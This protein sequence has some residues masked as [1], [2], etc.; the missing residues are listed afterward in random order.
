MTCT[1]PG[2]QFLGC[3]SPYLTAVR[4]L[5]AYSSDVIKCCSLITNL[6]DTKVFFVFLRKLHDSFLSPVTGSVATQECEK[7]LTRSRSHGEEGR[8]IS[9]R[10]LKP[11]VLLMFSFMSMLCPVRTYWHM[12]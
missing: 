3:L 10:I 2:F 8:D 5:R 6:G 12:H 1:K 9:I 7:N 11:Y 4:I